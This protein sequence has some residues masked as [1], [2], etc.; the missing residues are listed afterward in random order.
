VV[1]RTRQGQAEAAR[2]RYAEYV[3]LVHELHVD[4]EWGRW[5]QHRRELLAS[6]AE[7]GPE[8]ADGTDV[9]RRLSRTQLRKFWTDRF[10]LPEIRAMAGAFELLTREQ[11]RAA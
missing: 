4:P 3:Q 7:P 9:F 2:K 6:I 5:C 10:T 8:E 11:E 1:P